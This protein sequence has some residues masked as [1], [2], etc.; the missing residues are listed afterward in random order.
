MQNKK[1]FT[2]I[3]LMIVVAI[4]A[5]L[6]MIAVP[7]FQRYIERS[8][9]SAAQNLLHHL[10]TAMTAF[11]VDTSTYPAG[12]TDDLKINQL[13]AYGFRV[14]QNVGLEILD[15]PATTPGGGFIAYAAHKA[16]G[17]RLYVYDNINGTGVMPMATRSTTQPLSGG[18]AVTTAVAC[19]GTLSV[20]QPDA[21]NPTTAVAAGSPAT[22]T[23]SDTTGLIE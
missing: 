11:N 21:T 4:I 16:D 22:I 10:A 3:E 14:D 13:L 20:W 9:N 17:S 8:R 2:L 12:A 19:G 1:G 18:T 5:I 15:A 23:A 6:A 7:M